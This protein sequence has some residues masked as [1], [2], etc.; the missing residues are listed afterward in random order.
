LPKQEQHRHTA[1]PTQ[2]DFEQDRFYYNT[3]EDFREVLQD[4]EY[5]LKSDEEQRVSKFW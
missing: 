2:Q 4:F 1:T 5:D 3:E